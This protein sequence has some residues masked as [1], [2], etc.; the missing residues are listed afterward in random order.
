MNSTKLITVFTLTF[1]ILV[2]CDKEYPKPTP[3]YGG[4]ATLHDYASSL[5]KDP[6]PMVEANNI[7]I[8]WIARYPQLEYVWNSKNPNQEGWPGIGETVTW[9]AFI[10]NWE[11]TQKIN[12]NYYW[13]I[14]G[15]LVSNGQ[16]DL[17][18]QVYT[19]L[20]LDWTWEFERHEITLKVDT[21]DNKLTIYSDA[22]SLGLYV[23]EGFYYYFHEHQHK[24]NIG[25]NSF[26]GW[27]QRQIKFYNQLF[28]NAVY[29]ITPQGVLDRIRIDQIIIVPDGTLASDET[30]YV[31][32]DNQTID[33]QWGFPT[34]LVEGEYSPYQDHTS[35][36]FSKQFY[37][38][39]FLQHE[40]GHARY[41]IDV[42]AL[43]I[44]HDG[45]NNI[46]DIQER[47]K[48]IAG[49][50]YL[51]GTPVN[52]NGNHI[53]RVYKTHEQGLMTSKWE[54]LDRYSA[55][56]LNRIYHH[57]ETLE[58][59][60]EAET[61]LDNSGIGR[62]LYDLPKENSFKIMDESG[63]ILM[64]ADV[65]IFQVSKKELDPTFRSIYNKYFD[66]I[67]D[68]NLTTDHIGEVLLGQNPFNIENKLF[69]SPRGHSNLTFI[70]RVMFEN[71]VG[72]KV[73][74]ISIFNIEYWKGNTELA[75]YDICIELHD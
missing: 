1:F 39:G 11:N 5:A 46:I 18:P 9:T 59:Y 65:S 27:A 57:R 22:L 6:D 40:I 8:G 19:T 34:K 72:Y 47:G 56:A 54:W 66:N 23:E 7:T 49:T 43:N 52:L 4:C 21:E 31:I 62:Y 35:V 17:E 28:E 33:L 74:D 12:V 55:G 38:S 15:Q 37:Y 48:S 67:P 36:E 44:Y 61:S 60:N 70:M 32:Q 63:K 69:D 26:E 42:Y 51:P 68:I 10:K 14:D 16:I 2:G 29:D 50:L 30:F 3:L 41:L 53:I 24:L 20:D 13:Y 64:N 45:I 75:D 71:K 25:S 58:N 73:I